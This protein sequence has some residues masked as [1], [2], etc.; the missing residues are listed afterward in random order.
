L[1]RLWTVALVQGTLT[2]EENAHISACEECRLAFGV[3]I[4]ADSFAAVLK[5]LRHDEE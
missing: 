5:E 3:C 2:A 1:H 4:K